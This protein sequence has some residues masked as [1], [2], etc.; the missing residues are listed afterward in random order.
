MKEYIIKETLFFKVCHRQ[1]DLG[2]D[3]NPDIVVDF[4]VAT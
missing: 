2:K 3:F 4:E 1:V